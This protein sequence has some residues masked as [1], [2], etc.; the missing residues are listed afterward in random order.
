MTSMRWTRPILLVVVPLLLVVGAGTWWLWSGRYVAT[1]NA[2]V[3]ADI[4]QVSSEVAGR[5]VDVKVR[6]HA[7]VSAG[8]MLLTI[9]PEPYAIALA[10]AEA[11]LDQTRSRVAGFRAEYA[12][13][14]LGVTAFLTGENLTDNRYSA[15]VQVDNA[16]GQS[17]ELS[18]PPSVTAA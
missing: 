8:D 1:E 18:S 6:E 4:V 11:E 3:K 13:D 17:F 7:H 2:Y 10:K 5:I 14:R 9:D 15:S 12:F 16:A